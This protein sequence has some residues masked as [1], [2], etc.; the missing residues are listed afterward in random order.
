MP[1]VMPDLA[2][3]RTVAL[4]GAGEEVVLRVKRHPRARR[5]SLRA[6]PRDG[7]V[8]LVLPAR[9]GLDAGLAFARSQQAWIRARLAAAPRPIAFAHGTRLELLG[10]GIEIFHDPALRGPARREGALLVVGGKPEFVA[11]RVRD[12]LRG[13]AGRALGPMAEAKARSIGKAIRALRMVD[14]RARWGS[15]ARDARISLSWRL[16]IA[17]PR[18]ADYVV[19]H[20]VAHLAHHD[21]S[22][23]F[24]RVVDALTPHRAEAQVWLR[25]N[26]A[27][28]LG[29]GRAG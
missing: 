9:A 8:V 20:E 26:G 25:A 1:V 18:V 4:E 15:C 22:P 29:A 28:L 12:F 17:P 16:A 6:D 24:W 2:D 19:A 21:H 27:A 11:R 13:E 10:E 3:P 5:I 14:T 23:A 7:A